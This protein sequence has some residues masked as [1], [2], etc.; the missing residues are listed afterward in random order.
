MY[1]LTKVSWRQHSSGELAHAERP[2]WPAWILAFLFFSFLFYHSYQLISNEHL[3]FR[4]NVLF[5]AD[6]QRTILNTAS[7]QGYHPRTSVHPLFLI[8]VHLPGSFLS[9]VSHLSPWIVSIV[10]TSLCGSMIVA[11]SYLFFIK[12]TAPRSRAVLYAL[13]MGLTSSHFFFSLIPETFIFGAASLVLFYLLLASFRS[14]SYLAPAAVLVAGVTVTNFIPALLGYLLYL[15][16]NT[17][18]AAKKML[19]FSM[20][21]L[22]FLVL[23][24]LAQIAFYPFSEFVFFKTIK[25]NRNALRFQKQRSRSTGEQ[26][27]SRKICS[28][29]MWSHQNSKFSETGDLLGSLL[30]VLVRFG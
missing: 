30:V 17:K 21:F 24:N 25:K 11:F 29:T 3:Q 20:L 6:I 13:I 19:R 15:P 7:N 27:K 22:T 28:R 10:F 16:G 5:Q 4:D 2:L 1:N 26:S 23:V 8:L 14:E 9:R 18:L 12:I